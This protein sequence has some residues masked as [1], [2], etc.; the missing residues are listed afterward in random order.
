MVITDITISHKLYSAATISQSVKFTLRYFYLFFV[1]KKA[2]FSDFSLL[3]ANILFKSYDVDTKHVSKMFSNN[4]F[5]LFPK[6]SHLATQYALIVAKHYST[7]Y[8]Y[9]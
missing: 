3:N 2:I 6:I 8:A 1:L 9:V 4:V 5:H 7:F